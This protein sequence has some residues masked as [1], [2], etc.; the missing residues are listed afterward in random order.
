MSRDGADLNMRADAAMEAVL[1]GEQPAR[2]TDAQFEQMIRSASLSDAT[3]SYESCANRYARLCLEYLEAHPESHSLNADALYDA[4]KP[5][6]STEDRERVLGELTRFMGGWGANAARH[7]L[8]LHSVPN[9]AIITIVK[10]VSKDD[11]VSR[12]HRVQ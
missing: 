7:I 11:R 2:M 9:P 3:F 12:I 6:V 8:K 1:G 10:S 5:A 4:L